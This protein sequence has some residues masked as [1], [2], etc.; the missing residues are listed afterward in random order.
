MSYRALRDAAAAVAERVD[1]SRRVAVWAVNE[2]EVAV[3]VVGALAAGVPIALVNPKAGARELA[4][5]LGDS[6]PDLLLAPPDAE[7]PDEAAGR[8]RVDVDLEARGGALPPEPPD[9][10]PALIVYTSGTTGPPK[11]AVLPR[12][13]LA[14]NLDALAASWEWTEVDTVVHGL[15]LFHVHGLVLGTLGPLP[16]GGTAAHQGRFS[17]AAEPETSRRASPRAR[18]ISGCSA[19]SAAR[20]WYIV[21]TANSIV[22]PAS[23]AAAAAAL[24]K[25]P[26]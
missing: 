7:L 13:A 5:I 26:R 6:D 25:R 24:E 15:P 20:R 2:P 21:G 18:A 9:D 14:S 1:G 16:R 8:E 12:R 19:A 11:G 4:H 10:A 3:A 23:M 17:S 22:P